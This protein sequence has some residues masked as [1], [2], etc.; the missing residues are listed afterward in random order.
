MSRTCLEPGRASRLVIAAS[1]AVLVLLRVGPAVAT[2]HGITGKKLALKP[3]K[4]VLVSKDSNAKTAESPL[5]PAADSSLTFSDGTHSQTF[6]LPCAKWSS[7]GTTF[8]YR[9]A[10]AASGPALIKLAQAGAGRLRVAGYGLGGFPIPS[11]PATID[12]L[13]DLGG[14]VERYCMAFTGTGNGNTLFVRDAA[15]AT[16]P[17]CGNGIVEAGEACDGTA[18]PSCPAECQ[19]DCTCPPPLC[20]NG[21]REG[22]EACDGADAAACPA[23]CLSDCTCASPCPSAPGDATACVAFGTQPQCKACCTDEECVI[24]VQAFDAGC[25]DAVQNDYCRLAVTVV[26]CAATCCPAP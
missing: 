6:T 12:V 14:A 15:A 25:T 17:V 23:G 11:G 10:S 26:G 13:L 21:V 18:A 16:C 22:S 4:F 3:T 5:C 7:R 24:C 19:A 20:G 8:A 1:V 2:D 9:D